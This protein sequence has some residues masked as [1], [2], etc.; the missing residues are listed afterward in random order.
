MP[1]IEL[2]KANETQGNYNLKFG[3]IHRTAGAVFLN[4][5]FPDPNYQKVVQDLRFRQ[6]LNMALDRQEI[7]DAVYYGYAE[8]T[9]LVPSKYDVEGAKAL[10][11]EMGMNKMD[12]D[13]FR[14]GPDGKTFSILIEAHGD[15]WDHG[16]V[17]ILAAQFWNAIGIKTTAKPLKGALWGPKVNANELQA[18]VLFED[19]TLW[20]YQDWGQGLWGST[21]R[22]WQTSG[23]KEGQ[24]PPQMVKDM[25]DKISEILIVPIPKGRAVAAEVEKMVYDNVLYFP[26]SVNHKQPRIENKKLGN[27]ST[28]PICFSIT[29][30]LAMAQCYYKT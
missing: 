23:G 28:N 19:S 13:G 7:I 20:Y 21:W 3:N 4:Q 12:A 25:Y 30:T 1:K 15:F 24:E 5:T 14:I 6:A 27:V 16:P 29:Q 18:T 2:Y 9:T 22:T 8:P 10:L 11:D 17:G 26:I